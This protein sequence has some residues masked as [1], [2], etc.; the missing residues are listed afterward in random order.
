MK[1]NNF[2]IAITS[3][4][5]DGVGPEVTA[6]A[7]YKIGPQRGVHFYLWRS[8]VFQKKYLRLID[9]KFKRRTFSSWAEAFKYSPGGPKELIDICSVTSP[10]KWVESVAE[11]GRFG[12]VDALVT[13]PLSK[14]LIAESGM[15]DVGHT[16]ILSRVCQRQDLFMTFLGEQFNVLLV[17]G[18]LPL[19]AVYEK[20]DKKTLRLALLAASS[21]NE[22]VAP[23]RSKKEVALVGLNPHAGE[24]GLIGDS[25]IKMFQPLIADLQKVNKLKIAGP[26]V[27]DAAFLPSNWKR[28][29]VY[30]CPY[31]DQGLIP[32]KVVHQHKS[33]C[34]MTMGL[35][36]IRTSVEHGT[37]KDIFGK[38]KA[39]DSSM[40]DALKWAI[41]LAKSSF[42]ADAFLTEKEN[43]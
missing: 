22:F 41:V 33:G 8:S 35:P 27:P 6:K 12:H 14:T 19:R 26:L 24:H 11:A 21:I 32:F 18:H 36:F 39:N 38:D 42:K 30:V 40:R 5:Q 13:A 23:A 7:L 17:T 34:H 9:K 1:K 10:P 4:D 43:V 29:S 3:G 15:K 2:K 37:A 31:H 20:L 16:D 25:E 28:Y